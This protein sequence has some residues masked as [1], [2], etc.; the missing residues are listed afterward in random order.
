M[1]RFGR[2]FPS[3]QLQH[4]R[5]LRNAKA[6]V[7]AGGPV[8]LAG[9]IVCQLRFNY[10]GTDSSPLTVNHT[11]E[12]N[13][14][15]QVNITGGT[16]D[17]ITAQSS[18]ACLAVLSAQ[19]AVAHTLAGSVVDQLVITG[20]ATVNHTL[21]GSVSTVLTLTDS[22]AT[23]AHP[24][25][26]SV[27]ALLTIKDSFATVAHPLSGRI[28]CATSLSAGL[29]IP[30]GGSVTGAGNIVGDLA[31]AHTLQGKID[32]YCVLQQIGIF[33]DLE[34]L[35]SLGVAHTLNG[36]SVGQLTLQGDLTIV[37]IG[38]P[39][40]LLITAPT[41]KYLDIVDSLKRA[42]IVEASRTETPL[43]E[44]III[45]ATKTRKFTK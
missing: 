20:D 13:I 42:V 19:L 4:E 3:R 23:V 12:S 36:L 45:V 43:K 8:A 5:L 11:L 28:D 2:S 40:P 6:V 34:V 32:C 7:Q 22:F 9:A 39:A 14:V 26:S 25:Q 15:T 16:V 21:Q 33:C 31:V 17:Q 37:S 30:G 44:I 27:D 35:G 41:S 10:A 1:A 24:L 29:N 38:P 18:V